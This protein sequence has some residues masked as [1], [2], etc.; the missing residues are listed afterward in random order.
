M[1]PVVAFPRESCCL[2]QLISFSGNEVS[3]LSTSI[4][5]ARSGTILRH[6]YVVG[7]VTVYHVTTISSW[8]FTLL[9]RYETDILFKRHLSNFT[10]ILSKFLNVISFTDEGNHLST[11]P[12]SLPTWNDGY[13]M[14]AGFPADKRCESSSM[15]SGSKKRDVPSW[16]DSAT[17]NHA[18]TRIMERTNDWVNVANESKQTP[19][20]TDCP[21]KEATK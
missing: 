11:V 19:Q 7:N 15:T 1:K 17:R 20:T 4:D 8:F 12:S 10:M 3:Y 2:V 6:Q 21:P 13:A 16:S 18:A 9:I 14:A 5:L